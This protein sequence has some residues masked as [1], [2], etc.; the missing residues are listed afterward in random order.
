MEAYEQ[1]E[2]KW[3]EFIRSFPD[4]CVACSS[5][6]AALHLA[7][8]ALRVT[9]GWQF[10]DTMT[11]PEVVVPDFTM[12]ACARAVTMAGLVPRFADVGELGLLE[13]APQ[14]PGDAIMCVHVYG[15]KS[16]YV[17]AS[18]VGDERPIIEDLAEAPGLFIRPSSI[19]C[20]SFYKNKVIAGE[21]G[22]MVKFATSE[23]AK[24]GRQLRNMGFTPE[25]N[26]NHI[27]RGH[28]YRMSNVHAQLILKSLAEYQVN[29]AKRREMEG[30]YDSMIPSEMQLPQRDI[31]WVY[32]LDL[33]PGNSVEHTVRLLNQRGID[34][35]CSFKP[36]RCQEEYMDLEITEV[37]TTEWKSDEIARKRMYLPIRPSVMTKTR[38]QFNVENLLEITAS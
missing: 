19:G 22:G 29:I 11:T 21:E 3:A 10:T 23:Q 32:D 24:L 18:T 16:S 31:P 7:C 13:Y 25:H 4:L 28:N 34:A 38:V 20:W 27:P 9:E 8:E 1:L 2:R 35:R 30:W 15:R 33:P 36:L 6:T 5:G 26:F 37:K 17:D 12:I 14:L